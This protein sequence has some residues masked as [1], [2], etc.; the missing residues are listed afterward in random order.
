MNFAEL[1][2]YSVRACTGQNRK[3]E[4]EN[5]AELRQDLIRHAKIS[6]MSL[7]SPSFEIYI[8]TFW[9]TWT[10]FVEW[11]YKILA[12]VCEIHHYAEF[13]LIL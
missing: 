8:T 10:S 13:R 5:F 11:P 12:K 9:L 6:E 2:Q 1:F 7:N 3:W 4:W